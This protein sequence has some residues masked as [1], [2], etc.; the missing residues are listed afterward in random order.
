MTIVRPG[1]GKIGT[2]DRPVTL[3]CQDLSRKV[4]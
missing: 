2:T 3:V 1:Q 4:K